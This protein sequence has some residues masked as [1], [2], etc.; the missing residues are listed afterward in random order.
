MKRRNTIITGA[1]LLWLCSCV[2]LEQYPD[3][4]Y[5]DKDFWTHPENVRAALYLGYNQCWNAGKFWDNNILSDDVYGSRHSSASRDVAT[6]VATTS[7][8]R[9]SSEWNECYQELRTLH[10]ALDNLD[11]MNM[12]AEN[13]RRFEAEWRLMRAFTYLRLVTWFGD[14]PFITTNPSLEE[15]KTI[16]RTS[17]DVIRKF[18]HSE[19]EYA[20]SVLPKNTALP[21]SENGRYTA[22]TAIAI[23]ARA[24]LWENNFE[25]C[26]EQCEKLMGGDYGT[27]DLAD[28]FAELFQTGE[29]GR[30]SVMTIEFAH[31]G[32]VEN[33]LRGWGTSGLLPQTIGYPEGGVV[34]FSPTQELVDCF[35]KL[36]G[37]VAAD[38]DY[39]D[40][41]KRF[42]ATIA[43]NRCVL[44]IPAARGC[45]IMGS[46]GIG[47]GTYTCYTNPKDEAEALKSDPAHNDSVNG[48]QDRTVTGYYNIKNY[49]PNTVNRGGTSYKPLMEIRYAEVLLMY[50]ESKYET[51]GMTAEI[52]DKTIGRLRRRAGFRDSYLAMPDASQLREAIRNERRVELA[53]EGKRVFDLRRWAV[54]ADPGIKTTGAP[55]LTGYA[56]GAPFSDD[57]SRLV[58]DNAYRMKYWFPVPQGER[59]INKSLSQNPGW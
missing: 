39:K 52:W 49:N 37:S 20:A 58:C 48:S 51:G 53:L 55:F 36:D 38:T 2:G 40:R 56:T 59:D 34:S 50:A 17:E 27:Y 35:R 6:G 9:Y 19:L 11:R 41:D 4:S 33:V 28:D 14:V 3:N 5:T 22:G 24:Y 46:E 29:Y 25:A 15:S 10:T 23:N 18:I 47:K 7:G 57:G 32:G 1:A 16:A 43:Y 30:E 42:Y 26:A 21:A 13:L 44:A 54:L 12:D 8:G 45:K 31:N